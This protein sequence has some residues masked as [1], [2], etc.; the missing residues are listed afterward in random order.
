M[1]KPRQ[2]C[3]D[4]GEVRCRQAS[5]GLRLCSTI[6]ARHPTVRR[7]QLDRKAMEYPQQLAHRRILARFVLVSALFVSALL[8]SSHCGSLRADDENPLGMPAAAGTRGGTL[9]I[10]GGGPTPDHVYDEFRRLAGGES[11]RIVIIPS[12]RQFRSDAD[13]R[14]MF[15]KWTTYALESLHFLDAKTR[16]DAESNE[17]AAAV[18]AATG[19]WLSGGEQGRIA[20]LFRGTASEK[21]IKRLLERGGVVGGISAGAAVQS[22]VMIRYGKTEAQLDRGLGLLRNAVVDQHFG[23]RSRQQRLLNALERNPGLIGLGVDE[24]TALVVRGAELSVIG[25][26]KV[27]VYKAPA[28][29]EPAAVERLQAGDQARLRYVAAQ[30]E[31]PAYYEL[32]RYNPSPA[33]VVESGGQ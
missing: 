32:R 14:N 28:S 13:L 31:R 29:R 12:G 23:Q 30:S 19:V 10:A 2:A 4:S 26:G 27:S 25:V 17:F 24:G 22:D 33:S 15:V 6:A 20:D 18:D 7:L 16:A 1:W 3:R 11:A 8:A 9:F 21:A 5:H